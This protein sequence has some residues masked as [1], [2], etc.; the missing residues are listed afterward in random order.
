MARQ[1]SR[2]FE[3]N[4]TRDAVKL[5]SMHFEIARQGHRNSVA[6]QECGVFIYLFIY[7]SGTDSTVLDP[8]LRE[9]TG[10]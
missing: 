6:T 7:L 5:G 10:P 1:A 4:A 9:Q 2:A 3:S 8:P